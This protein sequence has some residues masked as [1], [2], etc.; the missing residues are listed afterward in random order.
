MHGKRLWIA[1]LALLGLVPFLVTD[2]FAKKGGK[3]KPPPEEPAADP[4][5]VY[6]GST[7]ALDVANADGSN[8]T[9]IYENSSHRVSCPS[10]S[11][12]GGSVA[13]V[14]ENNYASEPNSY[15]WRIDVDVVNGEVQT[16]NRTVL[17]NDVEVWWAQWSPAANEI[18]YI[19]GTSTSDALIR[20]LRV[21]PST[22]GTQQALYTPPAGRTLKYVQWSPSGDRI[23]VLEKDIPN[24]LWYL[25]L[26][27]RA[28]PHGATTV[29]LPT[30]DTGDSAWSIAWA[31]TTQNKDVLL[32]VDGAGIHRLDL[33]S[34]D[35]E[36]IADGDTP[37][38][39]PDDSQIVFDGR[40]E[41]G[42]GK[43][44]KYVYGIVKYTFSS[45]EKELIVEESTPTDPDWSRQ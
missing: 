18:A 12:D 14:D 31:K 1:A 23:A 10:W 30:V 26:I 19:A 42:R 16:S 20:Q 29:D 39:S 13:Y 11:G 8:K 36:F 34:G 33:V 40:V 35:R 41:T 44:K 9:R 43:K 22:G 17:V 7:S 32:Y 3:P 37:S 24:D 38:W 27:D 28:S 4:A 45:E 25:V 21:V 5:I 2:T 6:R 15:L